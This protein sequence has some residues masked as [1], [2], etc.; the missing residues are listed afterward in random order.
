MKDFTTANAQ[1]VVVTIRGYFPLHDMDGGA[2]S[3][4]EAVEALRG[5]GI[6]E[7]IGYDVVTQAQDEA[8][9]LL[10]AQKIPNSRV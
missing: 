3:I 4:R 6:A 5:Y 10:Q 9:V 7:V 2:E 8:V 1:G